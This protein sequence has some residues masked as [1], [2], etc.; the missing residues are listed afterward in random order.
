MRAKFRVLV[1]DGRPLRREKQGVA[2]LGDAKR[3][4]SVPVRRTP[5][6]PSA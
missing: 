1:E 6:S 3:D 5:S 4:V 2:A